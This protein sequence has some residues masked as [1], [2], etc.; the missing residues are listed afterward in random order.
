MA[1]NDETVTFAFDLES[2]APQ[3]GKSA[4]DALA[5]L[6]AKLLGGTEA[7]RDMNAAQRRLQQGSVIN[8][9]VMRDLKEKIAAQ[10]AAVASAQTAYIALGGTFG[11]L[12]EQVPQSAQGWRQILEIFSKIPG[13][14]GQAAKKMNLLN[15]EEFKSK[16][17]RVGL[18]VASLA[19]GAATAFAAAETFKYGLA[20]A[21]ARRN[22]LLRLEGL[23]KIRKYMGGLYG[24]AG[25]PKGDTANFLQ[26]QIDQVSDSVSIGRD[27]VAQF[28]NEL[29][30]AGYRGGN[31]QAALKGISI[32]SSAAGEQGE[33]AFKNMAGSAL[34]LGGNVKAVTARF[35]R[36]FGPIVAKQMLSL[37]TQS[38]K[39][40]ESLSKLFKDV[41]IDPLLE[42]LR[43]VLH[44]FDQSTESGK[45]LKQLMAFLLNPLAQA[46]KEVGP[47]VQAF[48]EGMIIAALYLELGYLTLR[49][50]FRRTFGDVSLFKGLDLANSLAVL[51][52]IAFTALAV[53]IGD[54]AVQM[55]I[56]LAPVLAIGA[57]LAGAGAAIYQ[58]VKLWQ[59]VDW[60]A[61]GKAIVTGIGKGIQS[62]AA[63]VMNVMR[64]LASSVAKKFREVLGISSPSKL[65]MGLSLQIPR[66]IAKGIDIGAPAVARSMAKVTPL[67]LR[68]PGEAGGSARASIGGATNNHVEAFS[69]AE[70][71]VHG[72]QDPEGFATALK[73][74]RRAD[75][76][77]E[78]SGLASSMGAGKR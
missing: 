22:E 5:D 69:G 45:Q 37:G 49:N 51:G 68:G 16:A 50:A 47:L 24:M 40:H 23:T 78:F 28:A 46:V 9:A 29:Y 36:D 39:F 2:N 4:A 30:S 58:L 43:S 34:L 75:L 65:M 52:G 27:K 66:G 76:Y 31:L 42:G 57:A 13:P 18:K 14:I 12:N 70:I 61:L 38:A 33:A 1:S 72:V 17:V 73:R 10:K 20:Q 74:Q 11:K 59:E 35:Q 15:D 8:V 63:W 48:F 32:A 26:E 25:A 62:G 3:V 67:E 56:L 21:D 53:A 77:A 19:L 7:L 55:A 41:K 60:R 54:A 6:K 71:H 64:E 44:I